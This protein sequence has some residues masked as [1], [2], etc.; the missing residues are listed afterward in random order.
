MRE[1]RDAS[2]ISFQSNALACV[3][4]IYI[5]KKNLVMTKTKWHNFFYYRLRDILLWIIIINFLFFY[6]FYIKWI[7]GFFFFSCHSLFFICHFSFLCLIWLLNHI[8]SKVLNSNK[9]TKLTNTINLVI[10]QD[11]RDLNLTTVSALRCLSLI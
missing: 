1:K 7:F 11:P 4:F 5:Y 6:F 8:K 2:R 10:I 9:N 3:L